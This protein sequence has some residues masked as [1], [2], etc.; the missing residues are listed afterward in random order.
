IAV[1][2]GG[3]ANRQRDEAQRQTRIASSRQLAAEAL[4]Q[5]DDHYDR[6]LLLAVAAG[7]VEN[8]GEARNGVLSARQHIT[9]L[10]TVIQGHTKAVLC[11][12]F[13]PDGETLASG[14]VDGT[15]ILW[16]VT[17]PRMPAQLSLRPL[18]GHTDWVTTLAF[19]SDGKTLAS[20]SA[21]GTIILWNVT[22]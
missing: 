17:D 12:A 22:N 21:D 2:F 4:T 3:Q 6:A 18:S 9:L 1:V 10:E 15:I 11:V 20:G 5:L 16:N 19:S 7:Q 14:S 8:T 13:S